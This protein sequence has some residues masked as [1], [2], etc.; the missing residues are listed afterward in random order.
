[1]AAAGSFAAISTLLGSPLTG[2]FLLM[3]ASG[4]GGPMMQLVLV[5]G[6]LAAGVGSLIFIGLD[7]WTGLGTFSLAIPGLPHVGPPTAA[8]FLWAIAIGIIAVP[9]G[10]GIRWLGLFLRPH[11][12]R[13]IILLTPVV[14]LAVAGLA[15][16]FA[17]VTGKGSSEVLFSGQSALGP[18][19]A[20][21]ASYTVGALLLLLACKSLAYGVSLSSFRGGPT[22]PALFIGA[23]G[24]IALSHL[25]G[26]PLIDGVAMG[27]GAMAVVMLRLP[28]TSVLLASLLLASDGLAV[29]PL[30]IVAV[31]V[32]Y[33]ASARLTPPPAPVPARPAEAAAPVRSKDVATET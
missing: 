12:E 31:V 32:A 18:L 8:G 4:L 29:M 5:P 21:N 3:E 27:I 24:G 13:R 11:V 10:S 19:I 20:H 22:F 28:L 25:P 17:A 1:M 6:L 30:V 7:A 33:V 15:I 14:G 23:A 9:L 2:A 16:L 26:L